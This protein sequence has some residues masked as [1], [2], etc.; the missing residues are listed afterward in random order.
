M[1]IKPANILIGDNGILKI[2][3]FGMATAQGVGDDGE[4]GDQRY[5]APELL[6]SMDHKPS[7]DIFSMALSLYET[8]LV[9]AW[10]ILPV[11]GEKWHD[12]REGRALASPG[13][14]EAINNLMMQCMAPEPDDRL[15][16]YE[17]LMK[18]EIVEVSAVVDSVLLSAKVRQPTGKKLSRSRSFRPI[19]GESSMSAYSI[20]TTSS[21]M[22]RSTSKDLLRNKT[23]TN[24]E[25]HFAFDYLENNF[26]TCSKTNESR[27]GPEDDDDGDDHVG[28][29]KIP[30]VR[31]PELDPTSGELGFRNMME[32]TA[33]S[34]N[35]RRTGSSVG[36]NYA[37]KAIDFSSP[38]GVN[39]DWST[40]MSS[41]NI[42]INYNSKNEVVVETVEAEGEIER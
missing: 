10:D 12:L 26:S 4:E 7:A 1:D 15:S 11:N 28:F 5:M 23:P 41:E 27:M 24:M 3:D 39:N 42:Q 6:K 17:L 18:D 33:A 25:G 14:P 21:S 13:R 20:D 36:T 40:E 29:S 31:S 2:G 22:V 32:G 8:C 16:T 34:S 19:E 37:K 35:Q 30:A 38:Q 9:P